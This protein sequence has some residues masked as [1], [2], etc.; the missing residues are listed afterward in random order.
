MKES[1]QAEKEQKVIAQA[2]HTFRGYEKTLEGMKCEV[3]IAFKEGK[4]VLDFVTGFEHI[5]AE[6]NHKGNCKMQLLAN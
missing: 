4:Y 3:I 2:E 6:V 1:K 5:H